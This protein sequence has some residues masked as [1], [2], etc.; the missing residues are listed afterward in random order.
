ME[1][2]EARNKLRRM[3]KADLLEL[4]SNQ[5]GISRC[6]IGGEACGLYF[7]YEGLGFCVSE[8]LGQGCQV[9]RTKTLEN[10]NEDPKEIDCPPPL[11]ENLDRNR[12]GLES[13][14]LQCPAHLDPSCHGGKKFSYELKQG[15][16]E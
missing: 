13:T 15:S 11:V 1:F 5:G 14:L 2:H 7:R 9:Q 16:H 3:G 6:A 4:A 8:I 10:W 12:N